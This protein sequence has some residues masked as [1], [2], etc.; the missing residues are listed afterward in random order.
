[1]TEPDS[2][3]SAPGPAEFH[4]STFSASGNCVEVAFLPSGDVGVRHSRAPQRGTLTFTAS[5][6][7]AFVRGVRAGEFDPHG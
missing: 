4:K 3:M 1:V 5:E 6:W 2:G 7:E